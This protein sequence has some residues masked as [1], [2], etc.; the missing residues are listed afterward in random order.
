MEKGDNQTLRP[1]PAANSPRLKQHASILL[2]IAV[3]LV[4]FGA[5]GCAG[6]QKFKAY[7][8]PARAAEVI[9]AETSPTSAA[10]PTE[11]SP[12]KATP[13]PIG[14]PVDPTMTRL[15]SLEAQSGGTAAAITTSPNP[16]PTETALPDFP[17]VVIGGA[18][19][20]AYF[21]QSDI[22]M[23]NLDGSGLTQLTR[24]GMRKRALNWLPDGQGLSY[25][26]GKCIHTVSVIGEDR[27]ITCFEN[28]KYLKA[29]EI[30][31]DGNQAAISLDNQ[32]YLLPFDLE[33]L[34]NVH[35]R[36]DLA[37]MATCTDLAPYERNYGTN[38]RW[39]RDS[40]QWAALI[41]GVLKNGLRGDL[42]QVFSV[43]RCVSRPL[44]KA[45]FPEPHFTYRGYDTHPEIENFDW[46]GASLFV[47]NDDKRNDGFGDL[48]IFNLETF[49][50]ILAIDPVNQRC[51]YRDT[52]WSPDG[53]YLV[54][55]YQDYMKGSSS[56]T[57]LYLVPYGDI[58][59]GETFKP[60]PL[61][62]ISDSRGKPMPALR[63]AVNPGS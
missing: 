3:L 47:F 46:D 16:L 1:E 44:L 15:A 19:K 51:C 43:D 42:V 11:T 49:K 60:L 53:T 38:I 31:P 39:S 13:A 58:G 21:N 25:I 48:H 45:Q 37:G 29:F 23:A 62:E 61:P 54:F 6:Y 30:S 52:R 26:S 41:M 10:K 57:Q 14:L 50:P 33:R 9:P 36:A 34:K 22:W 2:S 18:D 63:R 8:K 17:P 32:L 7:T 40:R 27:V 5:G 56:T 28:S 59:A 4:L 12:R 24:D 35:T 20:I 55:A